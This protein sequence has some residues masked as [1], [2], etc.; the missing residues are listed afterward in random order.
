MKILKLAKYNINSYGAIF[1]KVPEITYEKN[2][3]D[4]VGS[5][6]DNKGN[7]IFSNF[8]GYC[9]YGDAFGGRELTLKMKDGTKNKI[10]DHW[11]DCGYVKDHGE[12]I[13]IGAGTLEEMQNCFVFYSMNINKKYFKKLV[14]Q[15]L[16]F[17][18]VY[19]YDELREWTNLQYEW[20]PIIFH[21]K[22]ISFM[23]N[24]FGNVVEAETK[25]RIYAMHNVCKMSTRR[26]YNYFKLEYKENGRLI[27]LQDKYLNVCLETLPFAKEEIIK[28]CKLSGD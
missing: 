27:K 6:I 1:D 20:Y 2:G 13:D 3:R 16:K 24:K 15:Y 14:E 23:M 21:G 28:N 19:G 11:F 4:Y 17:D 25:K 10:K 12:F 22:K 8:L 9:S 18:K 5:V 7:I 26:T